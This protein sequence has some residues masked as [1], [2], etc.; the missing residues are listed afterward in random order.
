MENSLIKATIILSAENNQQYSLQSLY[1]ESPYNQQI[2][3]FENLIIDSKSSQILK[4]DFQP[5]LYKYQTINN[6]LTILPLAKFNRDHSILSSKYLELLHLIYLEIKKQHG[7]LFTVQILIDANNNL[8]IKNI[9]IALQKIN[10]FYANSAHVKIK[11][12]SKKIVKPVSY[13]K[14]F[15][16]SK[17][18]R[19]HISKVLSLQA[20]SIKQNRNSNQLF[21]DKNEIVKNALSN[22]LRSAFSDK[23]V[24]YITQEKKVHQDIT[25]IY[26]SQ[27]IDATKNNSRDFDLFQEELKAIHQL[28]KIY[29][30][31][32]IILA[33][34]LIRSTQEMDFIKQ[35]IRNF[36]LTRSPRFKIYMSIQIPSNVLLLEQFLDQNIDGLIFDTHA[37]IRLLFGV[38]ISIA[39]FDVQNFIQ[40]PAIQKTLEKVEAIAKTRRIPLIILDKP[41]EAQPNIKTATSYVHNYL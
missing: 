40:N 32:E 24:R 9:K 36:Q 12:I 20:D 17:L 19:T 22:D 3:Y 38:D 21:L 1:G 15:R 5:Q 11:S 26:Q 14:P 6:S 7:D 29:N 27:A 25:L 37:L 10:T 16:F 34:P 39:H 35:Y 31:K 33:I 23:L 13:P 4:K 30:Y 8:K 28:L 18:S 2:Y 41:K